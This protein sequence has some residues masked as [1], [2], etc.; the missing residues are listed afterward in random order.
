MVPPPAIGLVAEAL[1]HRQVPPGPGASPGPVRNR[2]ERIV[3][4]YRGGMN[5][6]TDRLRTIPMFA[7]VDDEGLGRIAEIATEFT[8]PA[9]QILIERGQPGSGVFIVEEGEASIDLPDGGKVT[10]GPG[11]FFG[12][13][14]LLTDT[15]RTARVRAATDVRGMAIGRR[16]FA[17]LL[18]DQPRIAVS[19]L[20]VLARRLAELL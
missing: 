10:G 5:A 1:D 6:T 19:M 14:S 2:V 7:H 16:D 13:I 18:Q 12:E 15:V 3:P 11:D 8:V 9:G 4:G 17:H 20:P